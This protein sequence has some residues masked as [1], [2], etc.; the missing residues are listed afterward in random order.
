MSA[1]AKDTNKGW[2]ALLQQARKVHDVVQKAGVLDAGAVRHGGID[3]ERIRAAA[4]TLDEFTVDEEAGAPEALSAETLGSPD[5]LDTL[6]PSQ[7]LRQILVGGGYG[8]R[9]G[10]LVIRSDKG[11]SL[12]ARRVVPHNR[13]LPRYAACIA[14]DTVSGSGGWGVFVTLEH[15]LLARVEA[16]FESNDW[17]IMDQR[18]YENATAMLASVHDFTLRS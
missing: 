9:I 4:A 1:P 11:T 15:V 14:P 10:K 16:P 7:I 6:T 13:G 8:P 2:S 3:I 17:R 5:A 12:S 18:G